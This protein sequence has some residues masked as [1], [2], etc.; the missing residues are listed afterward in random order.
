MRG[1]HDTLGSWGLQWS[2]LCPERAVRGLSSFVHSNGTWLRKG[3]KTGGGSWKISAYHGAGGEPCKRGS[4]LQL[5]ACNSARDF[6]FK[7]FMYLF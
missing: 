3:T 2:G 6:F 7:D 1:Q 4:C 5:G